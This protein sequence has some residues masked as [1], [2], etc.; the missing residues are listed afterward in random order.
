MLHQSK[1][2]KTVFCLLYAVMEQGFSEQEFPYELFWE[3]TLEK[4][5]D[6]YRQALAK[7][8]L[9][10]CRA[11]EEIAPQL[12]ERGESLLLEAKQDYALLAL[13]SDVELSVER[14]KAMLAALKD[15]Q[16]CLRD[17]RRDSSEPIE[18]RCRKALQL[19]QTLCQIGESLQPRL[20][21]AVGQPI[22][23]SFA[24]ALRRWLRIMR[25]CSLLASPL[26]LED[27]NEYTG[28]VHKAKALEELRPTAEAMAREI[29]SRRDE[30]EAKLAELLR[31]Y[32]P[33]RLNAVDKSILYLS[34]YELQCRK[35]QVAIVIS[36]AINLAH[37]FSGSKSAPFIHGILAAAAPESTEE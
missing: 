26:T 8:I 30:W 15:L 4:D 28:L 35:L 5:I 17:K 20:D 13:I 33:E 2:R 32:V 7:G 18:Q 1:I 36:E 29:L 14:T 11:S 19:A 23:E 24:G 10:A 16:A 37:E 22:A 9:H 21:D 25:E 3:I 27:K 12:I 6:H 31:N 34:L